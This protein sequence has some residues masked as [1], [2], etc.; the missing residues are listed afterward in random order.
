MVAHGIDLNSEEIRA[1]CR[2]WR[3]KELRVFGSI[4]RSDFRPDSD[5]D[6]VAD[7]EPAGRQEFD[8]IEAEEELSSILGRPVDL[9]EKDGLK[10]VIRDRVL[11]SS[12]VVYAG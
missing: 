7:F 5:V 3:I 4:L 10:W 6:F 11:N 9:V 8:V 12:Q 2:R 1:F